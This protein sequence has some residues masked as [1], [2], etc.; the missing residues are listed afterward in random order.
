MSPLGTVA[1]YHDAWQ[2]KHRDF[3][4]VPLADDSSPA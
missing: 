3:S 2:S 4:G 1:L